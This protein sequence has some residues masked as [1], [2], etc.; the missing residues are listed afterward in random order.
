MTDAHAEFLQD[1]EG[2]ASHLDECADCRAIVAGLDAPLSHEPIRI[3]RLPVAAWEGAAYRSWGFVA[4][5]SAVLAVTAIVMCRV[6]GVSPLHAVSADASI[7]QWRT[8]LTVMTGALRHATLG[9]Q[10]LF[11]C[12]FVAVNTILFLLLRRPTRGIDA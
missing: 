9:W 8:L 5:C 3:D 12:A 6:A 10:I 11:G 1:P 2:H 7:S 4:A